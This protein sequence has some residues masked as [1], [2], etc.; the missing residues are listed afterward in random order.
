M[1]TKSTTLSQPRSQVRR[2]KH[3]ISWVFSDIISI[4]QNTAIE[5][6]CRQ[7]HASL[8]TRSSFPQYISFER[9]ETEGGRG[10]ESQSFIYALFF[11]VIATLPQQHAD[12]EVL[13]TLHNLKEKLKP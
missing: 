7:G 1:K 5:Y 3:K 13:Q 11:A 8:D 4:E 6:N 2:E 10:R 9:G 12:L